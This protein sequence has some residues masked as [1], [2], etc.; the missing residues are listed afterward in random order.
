MSKEDYLKKRSVITTDKPMTIL[1]ARVHNG[2]ISNWD[3]EENGFTMI[4]T[5]P[6]V[7]FRD[8]AVVQDEYV[9][10]LLD[11]V[12]RATGAKR[13]IL[14]SF[15]NRSSKDPDSKGTTSNL[16][17]ADYA[18]TDFGP[19][20]EEPFRKMLEVREKVPLLEAQTCGLSVATVWH[21]WDRPAYKNPLCLVDSK[22]VDNT[23]EPPIV[24]FLSLMDMGYGK[25]LKKKEGERVP[26]AGID[27]PAAGAIYSP[28]HRWVFCPDMDPSEGWL[29]KQYDF[30]PD[31][32]S[33]VA[34]HYSFA[35]PFHDNWKECPPR[36]SIEFRILLTYDVDQQKLASKL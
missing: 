11:T 29:F 3:F 18:H 27:A 32:K 25:N 6:P 22:S 28:L 30:R 17:F 4:N 7:D 10:Q 33:K 5:P 2:G 1:D 9:P 24:P 12:K 15:A 34:F 36:R 23:G 31:A 35:D 13:A 26:I 19:K 21:P 16:S 14:M 8:K 20:F